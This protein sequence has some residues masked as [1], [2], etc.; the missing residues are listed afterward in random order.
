MNLTG[1]N[2]LRDTQAFPMTR[3]GQ[4][5]VMNGPSE[6]S[7]KQLKELGLQIKNK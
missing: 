2:T 4:T 6:L 1:E 5:S 3:S 7:E